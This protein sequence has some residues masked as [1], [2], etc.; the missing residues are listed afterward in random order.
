MK[1]DSL[2]EIQDIKKRPGVR[3]QLWSPEG[4]GKKRH[5]TEDERLKKE[6]ELEDKVKS[7]HDDDKR[8]YDMVSEDIRGHPSKD[9]SNRLMLTPTDVANSLNYLKEEGLIEIY[10]G[11]YVKSGNADALKIL[12]EIKTHGPSKQWGPKGNKGRRV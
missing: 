10:R 1:E 9:I 7:L 2:K 6:K 8:V 5:I 11:N 12:D 3:G 4:R